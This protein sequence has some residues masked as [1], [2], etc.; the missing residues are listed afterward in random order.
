[1]PKYLG[2][3]KKCNGLCSDT[4]ATQ[5]KPPKST[6]HYLAVHSAS[7]RLHRIQTTYFEHANACR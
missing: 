5:L 2:T 4:S 1:M 7:K 3:R 6:L